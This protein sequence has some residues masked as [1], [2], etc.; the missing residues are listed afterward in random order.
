LRRELNLKISARDFID[1]YF[2][3]K[4]TGYDFE[5]LLKDANAKF[6]WHVDPIQLGIQLL[7]AVELTDYP[8]MIKKIDHREW[9]RFF[10]TQAKK[11]KNEIF[12]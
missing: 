5:K 1:I 3:I 8:R 4:E 9:K 2:V 11:L 12:E 6:D 10:V 7:K